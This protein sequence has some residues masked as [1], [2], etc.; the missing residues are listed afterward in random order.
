MTSSRLDE[1]DA[2][3]EEDSIMQ[4]LFRNQINNAQISQETTKVVSHPTKLVPSQQDCV[5]GPPITMES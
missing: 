3:A 4:L 5:I 2:D 1:E